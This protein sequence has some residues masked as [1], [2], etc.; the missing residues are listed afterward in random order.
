MNQAATD[1]FSS[2][3]SPVVSLLELVEGNKLVTMVRIEL[4]VPQ[5]V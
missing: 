4:R 5:D 1:V 2:L 3:W